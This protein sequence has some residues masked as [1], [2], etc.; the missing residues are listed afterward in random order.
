MET[1]RN[2]ILTG[3]GTNHPAPLNPCISRSLRTPREHVQT[4]SRS[5]FRFAARRS[6]RSNKNV[7]LARF[8][9][10]EL[11]QTVPRCTGNSIALRFRAGHCVQAQ[12]APRVHRY[13]IALRFPYYTESG[14]QNQHICLIFFE[15]VF[16]FGAASFREEANR[17]EACRSAIRPRRFRGRSGL[18]LPCGASVVIRIQKTLSY[19]PDC[20]GDFFLEFLQAL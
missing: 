17:G 20:F 4:K 13:P 10:W 7:S 6:K 2:K 19:N 1:V 12:P 18:L 16:N 3:A 5:S 8:L 15:H 9:T 14:H 11:V